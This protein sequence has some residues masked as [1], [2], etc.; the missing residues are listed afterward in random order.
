[1]GRGVD[2]VVVLELRQGKE[3]V[4]VVLSLV[5]KDS[6]VLVKLLVNPLCLS[7]GLR[8]PGCGSCD[9]DS[10]EAV[11]FLGELRDKLWTTIGDNGVGK[12]M[13]FPDMVEEESGGSFCG[14]SGVSG[15][16]VDSL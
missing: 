11:E 10:E 7:V 12:A 5:Y 8:M 1:M 6:E 9:L 2:V 4:P 16:E 14:D 15:Y 13:E 3:I